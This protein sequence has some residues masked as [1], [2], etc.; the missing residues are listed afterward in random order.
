[1]T[2]R[3]R[4]A[5]PPSQP[6]SILKPSR[7]QTRPSKSQANQTPSGKESRPKKTRQDSRP[8]QTTAASRRTLQTRRDGTVATRR[9]EGKS[10]EGGDKL[11]TD[12]VWNKFL[13]DKDVVRAPTAESEETYVTSYVTGDSEDL[14]DSD[15]SEYS[16]SEGKI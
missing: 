7:T 6:A 16:G 11:K 3:G 13:D 9:R 2:S 4:T 10:G 12:N 8:D 15:D 5:P 1:M 14:S